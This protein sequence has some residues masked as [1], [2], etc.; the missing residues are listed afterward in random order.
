MERYKVVKKISQCLMFSEPILD[1][2]SSYL[3]LME[4]PS[5]LYRDSSC[6]KKD[7]LGCMGNGMCGWVRRCTERIER[8]G[9]RTV[10]LPK[11]MFG[12]INI[13]YVVYLSGETRMSIT[14]GTT[15]VKRMWKS[16]K[17]IAH[18][19]NSRL[20]VECGRDSLRNWGLT[21]SFIAF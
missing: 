3:P 19:V 15:G 5:N 7:T 17:D 18:D 1:V 8:W 2:S 6:V 20:C 11:V 21:R 14:L 12:L 4:M 10:V 13:Q 16:N 9:P